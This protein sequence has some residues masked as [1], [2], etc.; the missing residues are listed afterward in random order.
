MKLDWLLKHTP[1]K[2]NA[3]KRYREWNGTK[4]YWCCK[5][6][7]GKCGGAWRAHLP[8]QCKGYS[9]QG[10]SKNPKLPPKKDTTGT[11]RK[12]DALKLSAV[13]KAIVEATQWENDEH[14]A[15]VYTLDDEYH[16][17]EYIHDKDEQEN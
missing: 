5:E 15:Q 8:S 3:L 10:K 6:N 1:P 4:W 13:N 14:Q 16:A 12:S 11:K 2:P 9:K 17:T 7:G